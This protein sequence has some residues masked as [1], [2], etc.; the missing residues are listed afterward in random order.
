[1]EG[2]PE[3]K[4]A[5]EYSQGNGSV[6]ILNQAARQ[7]QIRQS[8]HIFTLAVCF[9]RPRY[10]I[11]RYR[12][13]PFTIAKT[14]STFALTEDFSRLRHF[15]CALERV[16][17]FFDCERCGLIFTGSFCHCEYSFLGSVHIRAS[18]IS[19]K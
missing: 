15:T 16:D 1:M 2:H 14:C 6:G 8:K 17:R 7:D 11:F 3:G 4:E 5:Q 19:A 10:H 18:I 9:C 13:L 12:N